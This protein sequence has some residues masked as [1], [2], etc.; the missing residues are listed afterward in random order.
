VII[1]QSEKKETFSVIKTKSI[2]TLLKQSCE[3]LLKHRITRKVF[4]SFFLKT[5]RHYFDIL[6]LRHRY[7][8]TLAAFISA[9]RRRERKSCFGEIVKK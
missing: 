6:R 8:N 7:L 3:L 2:V 1:R 9:R 4:K 5:D